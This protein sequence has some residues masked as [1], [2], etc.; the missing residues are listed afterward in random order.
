VCGGI[1]GERGQSPLECSALRQ[2]SKLE[3]KAGLS[4][5]EAKVVLCPAM[6]IP[7]DLDSRCT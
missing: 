6:C 7:V 1:S 4:A 5:S 2:L 3:E